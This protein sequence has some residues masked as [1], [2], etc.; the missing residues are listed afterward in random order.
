MEVPA[1]PILQFPEKT[2]SQ[3]A[4]STADPA[5]QRCGK[6][7]RRYRV[8]SDILDMRIC[9]V[10]ANEARGMRRGTEIGAMTIIPL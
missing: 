3:S 4:K 2:R 9:A 5:C 1:M 8:Q 7:S 10:C 6:Y